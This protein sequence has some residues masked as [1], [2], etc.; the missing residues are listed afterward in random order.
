[1]E[2]APYLAR[3]IARHTGGL[4]R[5]AM[6]VCDRWLAAGDLVRTPTGMRLAVAASPGLPRPMVA[7]WAEKMADQLDA[8][9]PRCRRTMELAAVC[10][11]EAHHATLEAAC[12]TAD[13][14]SPEVGLERALG[15]GL[16]RRTATGWRFAHSLIAEGLLSDRSPSERRARH[17]TL[18]SVMEERATLQYGRHLLGADRPRDAAAVLTEVAEDRLRDDPHTCREAAVLALGALRSLPRTPAGAHL[19]LRID[20]L[21]DSLDA[22]GPLQ[23]SV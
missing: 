15:A 18:L 16:V 23:P 7:N 10:A 14:A 21:I 12:R 2:I 8:L 3:W 5:L 6:E 9:S 11:P 22:S 17:A 20:R 1:M 13:A 4:P 19:R